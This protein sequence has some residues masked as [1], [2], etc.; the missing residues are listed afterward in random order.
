MQVW[1][2]IDGHKALG[3]GTLFPEF[4]GM[5]RGF[6]DRIQE[7]GPQRGESLRSEEVPMM[8]MLR[9]VYAQ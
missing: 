7:T 3:Y 2:G 1:C 6:F 8:K 9:F 5:L 4:P